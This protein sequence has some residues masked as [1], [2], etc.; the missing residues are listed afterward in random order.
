[1]TYSPDKTVYKNKAER[2][3]PDEDLKK[4]EAYLALKN[5]VGS[6][7]LEGVTSQEWDMIRKLLFESKNKIAEL[8]EGLKISF[9]VV[10]KGIEKDPEA[11]N[12]LQRIERKCKVLSDAIHG[13]DEDDQ[14]CLSLEFREAMNTIMKEVDSQTLNLP[15]KISENVIKYGIASVIS[16]LGDINDT[17]KLFQSLNAVDLMIFE[18]LLDHEMKK[19]KPELTKAESLE[20]VRRRFSDGRGPGPMI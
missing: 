9:S 10:G 6:Y 14:A 12:L 8:P 19:L 11:K 7:K 13:F 18:E 5:K 3:V 16:K 4:R 20:I 17:K 1:M 2:T 15:H